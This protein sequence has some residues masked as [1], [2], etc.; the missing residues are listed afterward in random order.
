MELSL[1]SQELIIIWNFSSQPENFSPQVNFFSVSVLEAA[2]QKFSKE[3]AL[4]NF[5]RK[6]YG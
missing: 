3:R 1:I 6:C 4:E 5:T 2:V